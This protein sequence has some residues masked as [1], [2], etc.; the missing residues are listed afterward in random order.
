MNLTWFGLMIVTWIWT[1]QEYTLAMSNTKMRFSNSFGIQFPSC[2]FG[3]YLVIWKQH[4][5]CISPAALQVHKVCWYM[6]HYGG[7]TPKRHYG[8]ANSRHIGRLNLGKFDMKKWLK[9]KAQ[10]QDEGKH[11][12]LVVKYKDAS[13]KTRWKGTKKLRSSE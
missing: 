11:H 10:L 3:A 7:P 8:F 1:L 9:R 6:I 4:H 13:G 2:L 12:E 5:H